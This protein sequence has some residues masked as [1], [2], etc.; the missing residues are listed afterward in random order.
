MD[1]KFSLIRLLSLVVD[2]EAILT[3]HVLVGD[4]VA[5][6]QK[7]QNA[8]KNDFAR[9]RGAISRLPS[10]D[11]MV[12]VMR[13]VAN[14]IETEAATNE[15][16]MAAIP[17]AQELRAMF[18]RVID[19]AKMNG[20]LY[21][22]L[23]Y[24]PIPIKLSRN[25]LNDSRVHK[26]ISDHIGE[27]IAGTTN[28]DPLTLAMSGL[29]P[30][31]ILPHGSRKIQDIN[32]IDAIANFRQQLIKLRNNKECGLEVLKMLRDLSYDGS[33]DYFLRLDLDDLETWTTT[34][35]LELQNG[36]YTI[37]RDG[38]NTQSIKDNDK[39]K[40][41]VNGSRNRLVYDAASTDKLN[42]EQRRQLNNLKLYTEFGLGK[43]LP[44]VRTDS[45]TPKSHDSVADIRADM[46]L[47]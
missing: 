31:L 20:I 22:G 46:F 17:I 30:D 41:F 23:E 27:R 14:P 25:R 3:T 24:S 38:F 12:N 7:A 5:D 26:A 19:I 35:I 40:N 39:I 9:L 15:D 2:A 29:L 16:E 32:N 4:K 18:G 43:I 42:T 45:E 44:V 33:N 47:G 37:Y 6:L 10:A 34:D 21:D 1:S 13:F 8:T 11:A 28:V 36:L